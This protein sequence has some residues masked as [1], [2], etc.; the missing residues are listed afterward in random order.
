MA[1]LVLVSGMG[2]VWM[3]AVPRQLQAHP[4]QTG[5]MLSLI[6]L[7]SCLGREE[8]GRFWPRVAELP[9]WPRRHLRSNEK[10]RWEIGVELRKRGLCIQASDTRNS[11]SKP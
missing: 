9:A 10:S 6:S 7:L 11:K 2:P 8:E 5:E 4:W 3:P 1:C